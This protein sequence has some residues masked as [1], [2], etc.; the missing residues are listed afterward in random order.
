MK[1]SPSTVPREAGVADRRQLL[2]AASWTAIGYV[3]AQI[4]RF[5]SNLVLTRLLVPDAFGLMFLATG[6]LVV[7]TLLCDA[8]FRENVVRSPRGMEPA[9]LDTVWS[10]QVM[11]GAFLAVVGLVFAAAL[12]HAERI[13]WRVG[14]AYDDPRFPAVLACLSAGFAFGGCVSTRLWLAARRMDT[15][16]LMAVDL[17]CQVIGVIGMFVWAAFDRS[18]WA[19]VAGSYVSSIC[20]VLISHRALPGPPNRF[21][22]E[23]RASQE[24]IGFGR[25]IWLSS[26]VTAMATQFDKL[27][28]GAVAE[29]SWLGYLSIA[30]NLV[31]SLEAIVSKIASSVGFPYFSR[32][33][34]VDRATALKRYGHAQVGV[35]CAAFLLTGIVFMTGPLVVHLLYPTNYAEAGWMLSVLAAYMLT[36]RTHLCGQLL[37]AD[38]RPAVAAYISFAKLVALIVCVA[39]GYYAFGLDGALL[40]LAAHALVLYMV[41]VC[42]DLRSGVRLSMLNL[43]PL[44]SL[45]VGACLGKS[46]SWM[47]GS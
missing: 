37:M 13:G 5:G 38:N 16:R 42:I 35:D 44:A 1:T 21:R 18:V 23:K 4:V 9:F 46:V 22:I 19:I 10:L 43:L 31:L 20:L 39:G 45:A 8:G 27:F 6:I 47:F 36:N 24:V 3:L 30:S 26:C 41:V 28:L 14:G 29:P 34:A 17:G 15:R 2:G 12:W 11:R 7:M 32:L 25:W 33:I 40:G